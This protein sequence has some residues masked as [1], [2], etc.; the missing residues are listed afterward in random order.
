MADSTGPRGGQLYELRGPLRALRLERGWS[1]GD[2]GTAASTHAQFISLIERRA[3]RF[4]EAKAQR[5]CD[6]LD[7]SLDEMFLCVLP[8]NTA[9]ARVGI[10]MRTLLD[11]A[12]DPQSAITPHAIETKGAYQRCY[13]VESD[14]REQL[15]GLSP[16]AASPCGERSLR[17]GGYCGRHASGRGVRPERTPVAPLEERLW[18]FK[19]E[20]SASTGRC[21][22]LVDRAIAEGVLR[23]WKIG[24]WVIIPKSDVAAWQATFSEPPA[25]E[26]IAAEMHSLY[27]TGLT[28]AE[29]GARMGYSR[30]VTVR[31]MNAAGYTLQRGPRGFSEAQAVALRHARSVLHSGKR[32]RLEIAG[33]TLLTSLGV[34]FIEQHPIGV[35]TVDFYVPKIGLVVEAD[36][37][38]WHQSEAKER[39]RDAYLLRDPSVQDV[40]H[41]NDEQLAP[42]TPKEISASRAA[43]R[44]A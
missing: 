43:I 39:A 4:T 33:R 24:G 2:L 18:L 1:Q 9:A 31:R 21:A 35:Y 3:T 14:L 8:T 12:C 34:D 37:W 13:F 25:W 30:D 6:A 42:W 41:L 44:A 40:L 15:A 27:E 38:Y 20:V 5:V 26:A 16:C 7:V 23:F 10:G 28:C 11:A 19:K 29:V 36:G 22:Q 17:T 32:T